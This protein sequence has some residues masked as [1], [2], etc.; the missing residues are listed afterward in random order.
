MTLPD[1]RIKMRYARGQFFPDT[2]YLRWRYD[3]SA[4]S[5]LASGYL[6]RYLSGVESMARAAIRRP[7]GTKKGSTE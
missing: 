3:L 2:E 1:A 7:K 4:D 5:S 6:K